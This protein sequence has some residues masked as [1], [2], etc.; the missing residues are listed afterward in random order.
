MTAL[1]AR[2]ATASVAG[3]RNLSVL[4]PAVL[5]LARSLVHQPA[6]WRRAHITTATM[7]SATARPEIAQD[8]VDFINISWTQFHAVGAMPSACDHN[9]RAS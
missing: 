6:P 5:R 2:Q 7:A 4:R 1:L 8:L 3:F 9:E